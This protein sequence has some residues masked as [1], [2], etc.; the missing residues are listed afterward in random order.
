[1]DASRLGL[2]RWQ[3][4]MTWSL[5]EYHLR[6]LT[7]AFCLWQPTPGCF[8]VRPDPTGRWWPDWD[9]EG[10]DSAPGVTA[11]WIT[12]HLGW[13][14]STV[15]DHVQDR[16]PPRREDVEWPGSAAAAVDWLTGL[17]DRWSDQLAGWQ[18]ADLDRPLGYPWGTPRPLAVGAAWVNSELMK[19]VSEIGVLR[20]TWLAR[21]ARA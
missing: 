12:W 17:H 10:P 16:P 5:A 4:S 7:D 2:L 19:N 6:E 18:D 20:H 9:D 8:T 21:E 13:W 1:M 11:G 3:L 14:W 15:L